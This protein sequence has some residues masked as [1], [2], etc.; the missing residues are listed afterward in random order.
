MVTGDR[1]ERKRNMS[2]PWL[3][4]TEE[5]EEE[6]FQPWLLGTEEREEETCQHHG[7]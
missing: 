3:L 7:Y 5:R 2:T 1:G 4:G 6:T